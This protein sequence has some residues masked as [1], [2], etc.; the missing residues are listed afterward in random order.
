MP[1]T[2]AKTR[3]AMHLI[4]V[5]SH[6]EGIYRKQLWAPNPDD[7]KRKLEACRRRLNRVGGRSLSI[8]YNQY[9]IVEAV[10]YSD[11]APAEPYE[12]FDC[13][14]V[15]KDFD[16]LLSNIV[17]DVSAIELPSGSTKKAWRPINA[18]R[19]WS[20]GEAPTEEDA[21]YRLERVVEIASDSG[22]QLF[23]TE[24]APNE[25]ERALVATLRRNED[26]ERDAQVDFI[27]IQPYC[28]ASAVVISSLPINSASAGMNATEAHA[29]AHNAMRAAFD[30]AGDSWR[31]TLK[32][33][34]RWAPRAT[35]RWRPLDSDVTP[36]QALTIAK[37]LGGMAVEIPEFEP[38]DAMLY[39]AFVSFP[40]SDD[41]MNEY[42]T[43]ISREM[44]IFVRFPLIPILL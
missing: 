21:I 20:R 35:K 6:C 25:C 18:C 2:E 40:V 11:V 12:F 30:A 34:P 16:T 5:M 24:L 27:A 37:Q 42:Q 10:V 1:G 43:L 13:R 31:A 4:E 7:L 41:R 32:T 29:I 3:W 14:N 28:D 23:I 8:Q 22:C 26:V 36:Q 15:G 39:A 44:S 17:A 9:G 38:T 33:S 19:D